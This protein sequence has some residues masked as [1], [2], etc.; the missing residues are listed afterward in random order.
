MR[1]PLMLENV[2]FCLSMTGKDILENVDVRIEDGR[3]AS[4]GGRKQRGD[5]VMDCSGCIL[6]PGLVNA[7]THSSMI[8]LRGLNDDAPLNDWLESMWAV[9]PKLTGDTARLASELAFLEMARYGT[10]A[11]LDQYEAFEAARAALK[12]GIRM[13]NGPALI[14]RFAP[15]EERLKHTRT[16]H[17][18][19]K[20]HDRIIP[21]VN[22]HS[23]YTN[24]DETMAKAG[25]LS[26][27]LGIPLHVHCSETREEVFSS[28]KV[29]GKL[30]VERLDSNGALHE[31]TVLAHMGWAASWEFNRIAE[32][33]SSVIHCPS[34]N[35]KLG[36]GGFFPFRDL[37]AKG[38]RI[39][40][41][42]D[43]AASNNTLD[44]FREMKGMALVQKGQYWDPAACTA[45]D[46]LHAATLG[47]DMVLALNG[48][49]IEEGMNADLAL[50]NIDPGILPLRKDNLTSALVY[51]AT[52]SMVRG[53]MVQGEWIY[54]DG[55]DRNENDIASRAREISGELEGALFRE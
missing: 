3:I 41:G 9:E 40:L 16:F 21:V 53:T 44:M 12:V 8:A 36:T 25:S 51:A 10:T 35:L 38:I 37:K 49:A 2:R 4:V 19:Y 5:E 11:C 54:L 31:H 18:R 29:T 42:T 14:S 28:R 30:A 26:R 55:K 24:D 43:S 13:A 15:A 27:E 52:G 33:R 32:A 45:V 34:S 1:E 20:G 17:E 39:G 6:I 7:H 47:G 50:L 23:I 46:A 48:G 22:L